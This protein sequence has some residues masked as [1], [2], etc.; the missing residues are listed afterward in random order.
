M[1]EE[2]G[3]ELFPHLAIPPMLTEDI[4]RVDVPGD[5]VEADHVGCDGLPGIMVG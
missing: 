3:L 4:G 1:P 5:M 2:Y